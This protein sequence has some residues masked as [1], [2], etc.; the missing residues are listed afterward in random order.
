V[1]VNHDPNFEGIRKMQDKADDRARLRRMSLQLQRLARMVDVV[2]GVSGDAKVTRQ[3]V[4]TF[5]RR[6]GD[7]FFKRSSS[8]SVPKN[9][10]EIWSI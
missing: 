3:P 8:L 10:P 9:Y 1:T 4:R 7:G 2:Y 6:I 5:S